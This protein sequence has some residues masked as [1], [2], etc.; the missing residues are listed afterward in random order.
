MSRLIMF[1][2][3]FIRCFDSN[4][5]VVAICLGL[6]TQYLVFGCCMLMHRNGRIFVLLAFTPNDHI[7]PHNYDNSS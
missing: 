1:I 5:L 2:A 3:N 6:F 7:K 4:N